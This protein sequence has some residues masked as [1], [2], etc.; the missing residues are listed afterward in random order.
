MDT[1]KATITRA[2]KDAGFDQSKTNEVLAK[3]DKCNSPIERNQLLQSVLRNGKSSLGT[4]SKVMT[5]DS[6]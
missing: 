1:N 2:C 3:F 6:K 4:M 5:F